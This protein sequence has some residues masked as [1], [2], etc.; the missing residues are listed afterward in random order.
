MD[1]DG[2]VRNPVVYQSTKTT[3]L[4]VSHNNSHNVIVLARWSEIEI[5][6]ALSVQTSK[7]DEYNSGI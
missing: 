7:C 1:G 3:L 6:R 2:M 5:K 4:W